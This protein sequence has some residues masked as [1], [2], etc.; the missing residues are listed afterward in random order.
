[1]RVEWGVGISILVQEQQQQKR[2]TTRLSVSPLCFQVG[3]FAPIQQ[4]FSD[5]PGLRLS[6]GGF[7][8][9]YFSNSEDAI[10]PALAWAADTTIE[11]DKLRSQINML[12][13]VI[14]FYD[15]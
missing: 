8:L 4:F 15:L 14:A 1:M 9:K 12:R 7:L 3:P 11:N 10:G 2:H 5:F 13:K 6:V